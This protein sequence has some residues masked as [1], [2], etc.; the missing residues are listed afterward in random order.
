MEF[1]PMK[2][3]TVNSGIKDVWLMSNMQNKL[4]KRERP[5]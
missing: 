1:V 2:P 3:L 5:L 4:S